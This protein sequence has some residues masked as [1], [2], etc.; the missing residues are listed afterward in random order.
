MQT[1]FIIII[2]SF[3]QISMI[4]SDESKPIHNQKTGGICF[5]MDDNNSTKQWRDIAAVFNKHQK[6]FCCSL[7]LAATFRRDRFVKEFTELC[8]ELQASGHEVM[9]HSPLHLVVRFNILPNKKPENYKGKPGVDHVDDKGVYL[10]YKPLTALPKDGFKPTVKIEKGELTFTPA[11]DEKSYNNLRWQAGVI[12]IPGKNTI[13]LLRMNDKDKTKARVLSLWGEDNIDLSYQGEVWAYGGGNVK[14]E[15]EALVQLGQNSLDT[16]EYMGLQR[17]YT[18]IQPGGVVSVLDAYEAKSTFGDVLG[19]KSAAT[20]IAAAKKVFNEPGAARAY[21]MQWGDFDDEAKTLEWNKRCIA[22]GV[23][24]HHM[25]LGHSHLHNR[26]GTWEEYMDR[27]DKLLAWCNESGI[28]VRTQAQWSDIL[29]RTPQDPSVDIFPSFKIDRNKDNRPDGCLYKFGRLVANAGPDSDP[30]MVSEKAGE[31]FTVVNLAGLERGEN[32]LK[33][34]I[35]GQPK[36]KM[37]ILVNY[38]DSKDKKTIRLRK[39]L[40]GGEWEEYDMKLDVPEDATMCNIAF[41]MDSPGKVTIA[42]PSLHP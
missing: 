40:K 25:M 33:F 20:Y 19:Y 23:A 7:N 42:Q 9:D 32:H 35:N 1:R 34:K 22:D 11:L 31:V 24:L 41:R 36:Q 3:F 21:G 27:L 8:K 6:P 38:V 10:K 4:W 28:E 26:I 37:H 13:Y 17:P 18:W 14:M 30:A 5:R 29:Y 12:T 16:F 2:L 39:D 15:A